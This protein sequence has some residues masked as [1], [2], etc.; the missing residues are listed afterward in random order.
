MT[1][2]RIVEAKKIYFIGIKGAGMTALAELLGKGENKKIS[3]SDTEEI[4]FTDKILKN[5]KIKFYEKFS[6]N[7]ITKEDP[8]LVIYSTAYDENNVEL[9]Y[10]KENNFYLLSY[11]EALGELMK[12][13]YSVAVCGT[14]GKTT[15]T[16]ML[17]LAMKEA[18]KNPSAIVGSKMKQTGSNA[19]IGD[20]EYLIIEADEYQ[21]KFQY[22]SP[23]AVILTSVSYDHPDFFPNFKDY[24]NAFVKFIEKI[25][26]YGFLVVCGNDADAL[27][28]A[29]KAKCK[30]IIYGEF[31]L[32]EKIV[33][34]EEFE[35]IKNGNFEIIEIPKQLNLQVAG[36]HNLLNASAAFAFCS[37][38]KL[39]K[40]KIIN[41][42][43]NYKGVTRRFEKLG[44]KNGATIIDDYA[45]HPEEIQATLKAARKKYPLK[46]IIC[47]FQSHTYTRT[48]FLLKDFAQ[49]FDNCDQVIFSDIYNSAREETGDVDA[50]TLA[51]ETKK[52]KQNSRYIGEIENIHDFLKDKI[53]SKDVVITMGA[54]NIRD[55]GE[56]LVKAKN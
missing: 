43:N 19:L 11:P 39:E 17:A 29:K 10:V 31:S 32:D 36:N 48:K 52:Y 20:S 16:A 8:D 4:F 53:T 47:V 45:H 5:L 35:N 21:N 3:G 25:P 51:A 27:E 55:L 6:I 38:L 2:N 26:S 50:T 44:E 24:K 46:N 13:K 33:L 40:Q 37:Q 41:A 18:G 12:T 1:Y 14:H 7:N 56:K 54:G 23:T 42:L 28:V 30:I 9:R 15:T 49:S 22:Y 34:L